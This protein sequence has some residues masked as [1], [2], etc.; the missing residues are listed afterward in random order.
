MSIHEDFEEAASQFGFSLRIQNKAAGNVKYFYPVTQGAWDMWQKATAKAQSQSAVVP[1]SGK[2]AAWLCLWPDGSTWGA[3]TA[4]HSADV[5]MRRAS[6]GRTVIPLYD[7]QQSA[8][9]ASYKLV[10]IE[11]TN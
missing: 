9:L 8:V 2:V 5:W 7:R 10:P 1:D 4:Q 11:P 3:V 6:E